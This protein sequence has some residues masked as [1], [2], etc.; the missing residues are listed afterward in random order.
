MLSYSQ[1]I[2]F[3]PNEGTHYV[4]NIYLSVITSYM[5]K[6]LLH[7]LIQ[8][9]ILNYIFKIFKIQKSELH[10]ILNILTEP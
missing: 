10:I 7:H 8:V 2:I 9:R 4:K 1:S 6:C 3:I 5:S